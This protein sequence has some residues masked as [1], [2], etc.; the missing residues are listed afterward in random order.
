MLAVVVR[1]HRALEHLVVL[2]TDD[3]YASRHAASPTAVHVP[4]HSV[5]DGLVASLVHFHVQLRV[6]PAASAHVEVAVL[7]EELVVLAERR[8]QQA[9]ARIVQHLA[10]ARHRA[11]TVREEAGREW[12]AA[13]LRLHR[14]LGEGIVDASDVH[15]VDG[16][17][18]AFVLADLRVR[19]WC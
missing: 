17:G 4:L 15:E 16:A 10:S 19:K 3:V 7:A 12:R 8:P 1:D 2:Q 6:I 11:R 13:A 9:L 18:A 14:G 5:E